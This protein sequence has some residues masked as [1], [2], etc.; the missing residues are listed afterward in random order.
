MVVVVVVVVVVR[1]RLLLGWLRWCGGA[2]TVWWCDCRGGWADA[3]KASGLC[4][5][6]EMSGEGGGCGVVQALWRK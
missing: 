4:S 6:N 3:A 5:A 1:F 2:V